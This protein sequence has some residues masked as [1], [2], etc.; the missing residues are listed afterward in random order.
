MKLMSTKGS[1]ATPE[2]GHT[3]VEFWLSQLGELTAR[4]DRSRFYQWM[5]WIKQSQTKFADFT[6]D[7]L[8]EFQK[9][10]DNGNRYELLDAILKPWVTT[11]K[12]RYN[13]KRRMYSTV[14]SF[15]AYNRAEL[16]RDKTF[17]LRGDLPKVVGGLPPLEIKNMLLSSNNLYKAIFLSMYQGALGEAEF[18]YWNL[19]GWDETKKQLDIRQVP[20]RIN[21]PGRKQYRNVRPYYTLIGSDAVDALRYYVDYERPDNAEGIFVT[22]KG[23]PVKP[24]TVYQYWRRHLRKLGLAPP[25]VPVEKGGLRNRTGKS[26]HEL[27]DS[28]RTAWTKSGRA[29][30]VAEYLMGHAGDPL[31]YD[32]AY[33]DEKWV[34]G[35]YMKAM[36]FLNVLT[37]DRAFGKIDEDE[38]EKLNARIQEL[39]AGESSEM[40]TLTKRL[41]EQE[42]VLKLLMKRLEET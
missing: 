5:R 37:N 25:K 14:R 40:Q 26:P 35:E 23:K 15:F 18:Q 6:P 17:R 36:P 10:T 1:T 28:F 8:I 21:L 29:P 4:K 33:R 13:T 32:K 20:L 19:N 9:N 22:Q 30:E 24:Y 41:D 16:P 2:V 31:G 3:S 7:Q 12:A 39:E 38:I 11:K 27:R 34:Q 42:K